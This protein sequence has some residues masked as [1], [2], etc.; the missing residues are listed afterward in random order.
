[1][2]SKLP[3][4][5]RPTPDVAVRLALVHEFR[6][7]SRI[8]ISTEA[9]AKGLNLQFC[10]TVINYDLPWNPQ[11]IE[12]RIGRCHRYAQQRDVT[13]INFIARDNEAQRLTFE[14][15]SQKLDLF[16]TVLGATDEVLHRPGSI[17]P[18][19]LASAL[20][21]DFETQLRRI[22]DRARTI[23]EVEREL[24][25][26]RDALGS[27]RQEFE[28]AQRRTADVIQRR[29]DATVR[30][31]FRRIQEELPRELAEF[32][33]HVERGRR[34]LPRGGRGPLP[35]RPPRRR[36]R[37]DRG[38][39]ARCCPRP[40][41]GGHRLPIGGAPAGSPLPPLH[42]GHPLVQAAIED[43]RA[44][45][46]RAPLLPAH[47]GPIAGDRRPCAAGAVGSGWSASSPGASRRSSSWS[48]WRSWRARPARWRPS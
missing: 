22:Y 6:H 39:V 2:G 45:H 14:I 44:G 12:Q 20:G 42:L 40:L 37:A 28:T 31:V 38:A 10:D 8:L 21:P 13:V 9:G 30:Q 27:K 32:D 19:A 26:L 29:F 1:M 41:R 43:I 11:R 15:L 7:R 33:R 16:G 35:D 48:R 4:D 17:A 46:P 34:R 5:S 23:E 47:R 18:E 25:A 36:R 24:A 3:A